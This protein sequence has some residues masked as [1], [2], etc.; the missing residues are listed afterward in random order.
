MLPISHIQEATER[1][2][3]QEFITGELVEWRLIEADSMM[4]KYR[5]RRRKTI[6]LAVRVAE[7]L[8]IVVSLPPPESCLM[9]MAGL[10]LNAKRA[11]G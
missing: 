7:R 1:E 6:Q 8:P 5:P 4:P 9:C 2:K 11:D 3:W 10:S